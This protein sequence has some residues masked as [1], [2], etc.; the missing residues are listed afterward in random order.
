MTTIDRPTSSPATPANTAG[1]TDTRS[2]WT[3]L[4]DA[5]IPS[6]R[7]ALQRHQRMVELAKQNPPPQRW[8]DEDFTRLRTP[9]KS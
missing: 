8:H 7:A 9:P 2:L 1:S 5:I 6:R 4:L 3:R